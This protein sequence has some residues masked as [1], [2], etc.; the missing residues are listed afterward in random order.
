MFGQTK[1]GE[2]NLALEKGRLTSPYFGWTDRLEAEV[3]TS[4]TTSPTAVSTPLAATTATGGTVTAASGTSG[5]ASPALSAREKFLNQFDDATAAGSTT[6]PAS[7]KLS[8]A[9][10]SK[11]LS[12]HSCTLLSVFYLCIPLV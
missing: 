2:D 1:E 5:A 4:L 8:E 11:Y 6:A 12:D 3:T 10:A 7:E 9:S